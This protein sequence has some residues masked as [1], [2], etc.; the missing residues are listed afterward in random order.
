M[1]DQPGITEGRR[2]AY[3]RLRGV[4]RLL[5]VRGVLPGLRVL[6]WLLFAAWL[7]FVGMQLVLR[8][9][10]LPRVA[11]YRP[12]I[13]LLASRAVGQPVRIGR[14]E[15]R[16]HGLNPDLVLDDVVV[17]DSR[18]F[19]AFTMRRIESVLSWQSVLRWRPMLSLLSFE[20]PVLHVRR[21][22]DGRI[23]VAGVSTEGESDPAFARW[24]LE[25]RRIRISDATVVWDDRL[26]QAP[27]LVLEDLQLALDN[28]GRLHR[29]GITAAPPSELAARLDVRGE[30]RGNLDEAL[31]HLAGKLFVELDYADLAG[32]RAWVDYPVHLPQGRGA[33]R[34]WGDLDDGEGRLIADLALE[35]LQIRLGRKV[36]ELDLASMRG[37]LEG[38]YAADHWSVAGRKIE[39]LTRDGLRVAPTDFQ[40]DLRQISRSTA[41]AGTASVNMVDLAV[42]GSLASHL[43]LDADSRRLL[44]RHRPQG[45]LTEFKAGW[46]L[47]GETLSKFSLKSGFAD[48]G[49]V[50]DGYFPGGQGFSGKVELT[51]KGGDLSVDAGRSGLSLPA[52]FPEPDIALDALKLRANWRQT[53]AGVDVRLEKLEFAGADAAGS[54][55]GSYLY[56]GD[57]PGRIDLTANIDRGDGRAV[58]RYMP[59]AV[60]ADAR[61]WIRRGITAGNGYDGR[62]V[63]KG[64]LKDFPFRDP[65]TGTFI[66]TAKARGARVD[67]ASGW[68]VIEDIEADM[69][70]GVG[71][72]IQASR[73]RLMG[74]QL[75]AVSVELPDFESFDEMLLVRG[76]AQGAT[77]EF[78]RFIDR[79]PVGDSIDRFTEGMKASGNGRLDLALDLPLRRLHQTKVRGDYRF[80]NNRVQ[81][82]AALPEITEVNGQL[83]ITESS[84]TAQEITGKGFGGTVRVQVRSAGD[85]VAVQAAGQASI[86]EVSKFFGWPLVNHLSGQAGWK[87]DIGIRKRNADVV[88]ESD[89]IGVSSPLPDPLNKTA[90]T[91]LPLRI[92]RM[93]PDSTREQYKITLGRIGQGLV[94]RRNDLWERAVL[95]VG[96][97]E[98]RLPER[99]LAVR[100]ATPRIDADAWRNFLPEQAIGG[101]GSEAAALPLSVVAL[102]TPQL[103]FMGRDYHQVDLALR[104]RDDG[105]QIG[106][107]T[108]EALGDLLWKSSGEGWLEGNLKRLAINP[109]TA[110]AETGSSPLDSLPGM[111]L[112][113]DD[114]RIGERALGKLELKARND[115]G[116]WVLDNLQLN[117]P[118]G[119]LK[120]RGVWVHGSRP[121]TRLDFE[122]TAANLGQLVSRLGYG[123]VIRR[124]TARL[125]GDLQWAGPLTVIH[126]P[127]LTGQMSVEAGKGQFNKLEPG[128]GKL[129]GLLSLQ[130]LP[131]RLTLDFRDI[132]SEGLA[133]D[134]VYGQLNVRRGIMR[135]VKP[136]RIKAPAAEIELAGETDLK[137]ETQDL[138]VIVRPELGTVAAVGAALINPVA[139]AATLIASSVISNPLNRLFSYRYHVTGSWADPKVESGGILPP[140]AVEVPE[141]AVAPAK[142]NEE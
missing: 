32:W 125:A 44:E 5:A 16:W 20:G 67:Y 112:T 69:S 81:P 100:V 85:K 39:L 66:V 75:L 107:N 105:W 127:S 7:I 137:A 135:T 57:G 74:A 29:F 23:T 55:R 65:A 130:A 101:V 73:G 84:V 102:R 1:T 71:M 68:P 59:H 25:Q 38:R 77:S 117:N 82:V 119:R 140:P 26:R 48:L 90:N 33:V 91:P 94:L 3:Y 138:R 106:L 116:A 51:E 41:V 63:L 88:V 87:A 50:A 13:E 76:I 97:A 80:I 8:Y 124:G 9:V 11:D 15:A 92:E 114:L 79:S 34:V 10:V 123:E 115:R 49:I 46:T 104:P 136:L 118:D 133:F 99:G 56:S 96:D 36:P 111:N 129:L 27:P 17:E 83:A 4:R 40:V 22:E 43:P 142:Q 78:L 139:G 12:D 19:P 31:E 37:R 72:K 128:V 60:N 2:A 42:L 6:G 89:L 113:V 86:V 45:Q 47:D 62:L 103:R 14:I 24:V 98:P 61:N 110:A 64:D 95:A 70:F 35:E 131:R 120:G 141:E 18:G 93:A 108:R 134:S 58:W 122:L 54:A 21:G 30:I 52:I 53:T 109:S 126:Y 28:R 121:Q 132:F